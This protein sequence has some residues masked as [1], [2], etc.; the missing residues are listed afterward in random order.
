MRSKSRL[1]LSVSLFLEITS[2]PQTS[3]DQRDPV[4]ILGYGRMAET[5]FR[6]A[7]LLSWLMNQL[8]DFECTLTNRWT[9]FP[10]SLINPRIASNILYEWIVFWT[11]GLLIKSEDSSKRG[12]ID[13]CFHI[14][15]SLRLA[16]HSFPWHFSVNLNKYFY[17]KWNLWLYD[18]NIFK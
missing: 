6:L 10:T 3:L 18:V 17:R 9:N 5:D 8:L 7:F 15:V 12:I 2:K 11:T 14:K 1:W 13:S 16:I 4:S